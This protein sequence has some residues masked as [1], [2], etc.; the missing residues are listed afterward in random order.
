MKIAIETL[1]NGGLNFGNSLQN[2]ALTCV[3]SKLTRNTVSTIA[4]PY[5]S[6]HT[7]FSFLKWIKENNI[8]TYL[9]V[10]L[11]YNNRRTFLNQSI[12]AQKNFLEFDKKFLQLDF[13][14][15][16][17]GKLIEDVGKYDYYVAGSDQIWNPYYHPNGNEFL[18][19]APKEKSI[20]YAA[21]FGVSQIPTYL[22]S[23]YVKWLNGLQ[24]ISVRE[25][26]GAEIVK[27]LTGRSAGV[28]VDPTLL[29][30]RKEWDVVATKPTWLLSD[31]PFLVTYFLGNKSSKIV[32]TYEQIAKEKKLQI[33][34]LADHKNINWY[35]SGPSE[36][37][38]LVQNAELVCT[39]SFHACVF[40]IIFNTP[41][42]VVSRSQAGVAD[43]TSRLD[44]L[45][46][47]FGYQDRFVDFNNTD[48]DIEALMHM[49][50]SK[51]EEIQR[52][53]K[54]RSLEFLKNAMNLN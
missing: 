54:E 17:K 14:F 48:I 33:I 6:F 9:A 44:T 52:R 37:L 8:K 28:H 53:E 38:Y 36:F 23:R 42:F 25:D 10:I 26:A 19:F 41:F 3:L 31:K 20:S 22:E 21:S 24:S 50:F 47:L 29:L 32:A 7:E 11:N 27:K 39:D 16:K 30:S 45:M 12:V 18:A 46:N 5:N 2:Y 15:I 34:N 35:S 4:D 40:S 49:D 43:M 51:V 1:M 13:N